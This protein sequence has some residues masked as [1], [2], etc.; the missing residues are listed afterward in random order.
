MAIETLANGLVNLTSWGIGIVAIMAVW[1]FYNFVVGSKKEETI[2]GIGERGKKI[3]NWLLERK[4]IGSAVEKI[5]GGSI[6]GRYSRRQAKLEL[7]EYI[8]VEEEEKMLDE[9]L[10]AGRKVVDSL[11]SVS[12]RKEFSGLKEVEEVREAIKELGDMLRKN[13]KD[14]SR[15]NRSSIRET[16]GMKRL[17]NRLK[18]EGRSVPNEVLAL[19]RNI[20]VLHAETAKEVGNAIAEHD[21]L[22]S[23]DEMER[24]QNLDVRDFGNNPNSKY[25]LNDSSVAGF[26]FYLNHLK[27]L[28][29]GFQDEV[30]LLQ[31]A[32][33]KQAEVKK[34]LQ[35]IISQI[36]NI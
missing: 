36:R 18:K 1:E 30:F 27:K 12:K 26:V 29:K 16:K 31:D 6:K 5:A 28:L 7:N 17:I 10:I 22:V 3:G 11:E 24:L 4:P 15:I 32:Y 13:R 23:S 8:L 19:E 20:L 34:E 2:G 9:S 14:F 33:K 21:A 35:G 25:V